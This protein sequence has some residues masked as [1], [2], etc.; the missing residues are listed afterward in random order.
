[1]LEPVEIDGKFYTPLLSYGEKYG[2]SD[3]TLLAERIFAGSRPS[4]L[5]IGV[6]RGHHA[7]VMYEALN[8][9]LMVLVDPW[10]MFGAE[11]HD[12][13][14]MDTWYR[15]QQKPEVVIM[16]A[17]SGIAYTLLDPNLMFDFIYLDGDHGP[18]G[19]DLDLI[20][21]ARRVKPGGILAG[22]DFNFPNIEESVRGMFGDRV[23]SN[24][25]EDRTIGGEEWWVMV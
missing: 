4:I 12:S 8:P 5:E 11:T 21:W 14:W 7:E 19:F 9:S 18:E 24:A 3:T 25:V 6:L 23:N 2:K 10:D 13:N 15:M 22:H 1:M 16:K 20:L 17:T